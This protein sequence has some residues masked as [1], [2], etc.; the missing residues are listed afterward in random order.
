MGTITKKVSYISEEGFEF[1]HEPIKDSLKISKT[2][3]GY[4]ARYLTQDDN[5]ISPEEEGDD[6]V[7]LVGYHRSF[8]V[9][10]G[11]RALVTIFKEEEFKT[12]NGYDGRAYADGYGWKSYAEAKAQGLINKQVRRGQY[13]AGISQELAV[14]IY[15]GGK[16]EDG[17]TNDEAKDYIR[18]YHI[19]GL[20]AY[21]HSG[22]ILSLAGQ[23]RQCRWDTS[24]LGVVFVSKEEFKS[25]TKAKAVAEGL[26]RKWNAYL[27][28]D[29]YGIVKETYNKNKEQI[30]NDS[31]WGFSGY[32]Y[33]IKSL[34]TD[35]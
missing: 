12:N 16:Y 21:I 7:F 9:D 30:D 5:P 2:K 22:V 31:C 4:E 6:N 35:I 29:I 33:A 15:N 14:C 28:G 19:F 3:N 27:N 13:T 34:E 32:D 8:T 25:R 20:E 24:Q 17:S 26:I 11:T 23:G 10:R 18:K 1:I